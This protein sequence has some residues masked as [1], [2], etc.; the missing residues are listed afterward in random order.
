MRLDWCPDVEVPENYNFESKIQHLLKEESY[1]NFYSDRIDDLYEND[2]RFMYAVDDVHDRH[3][4]N[5][6]NFVTRWSAE[7]QLWKYYEEGEL[8]ERLSEISKE[9]YQSGEMKEVMIGQRHYVQTWIHILLS[10]TL[11][12]LQKGDL[13]AAS[14]SAKQAR[15]FIFQLSKRTTPNCDKLVEN[16]IYMTILANHIA[17]KDVN[18]HLNSRKFLDDYL[19]SRQSYE[20]LLQITR[21][22]ALSEL[23]YLINQPHKPRMRQLLDSYYF[24]E[25]KSRENIDKAYYYLLSDTPGVEKEYFKQRVDEIV[26]NQESF[27]DIVN[28]LA[29]EDLA[30]II[31]FQAYSIP[32]ELSYNNEA[33]KLKKQLELA[34]AFIEVQGFIQTSKNAPETIQLIEGYTAPDNIFY[35]KVSNK[36]WYVMTT[37]ACDM[38]NPSN[39]A[40]LFNNHAYWFYK[41]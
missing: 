12:E 30:G 1:T 39:H 41:E 23:D 6:Y 32:R 5:Y 40:E 3:S 24:N 35:Q 16:Y 28:M 22:R 38:K 15:E 27:M 8:Y 20:S 10:K 17:D 33:E 29:H 25:V 2:S 31:S 36:E 26:N 11:Y 19:E 18:N 34:H 14:E 13:I 7:Q 9:M 21:R 4:A 37:A